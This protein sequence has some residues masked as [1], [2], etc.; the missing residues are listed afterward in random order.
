LHEAAVRMHYR[1]VM[2]HPWVNGNGRHARLLADVIIGAQGA[3]PLTWGARQDLANPGS[4]RSS[5]LEAIRAADQG[6]FT[7]LI[8]FSIS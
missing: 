7:R 2:V 6:E 4:A 8:R 3:T 5:Y 1:L